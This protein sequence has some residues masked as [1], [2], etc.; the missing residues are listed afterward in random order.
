MGRQAGPGEPRKLKLY[1]SAVCPDKSECLFVVKVFEEA[2]GLT[3]LYQ[4][5]AMGPSQVPH[6]EG[7]HLQVTLI[8]F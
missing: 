2:V 1:L 5:G 3:S 6:T 7:I 8:L 4:K